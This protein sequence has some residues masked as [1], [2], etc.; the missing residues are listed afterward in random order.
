M[1]LNVYYSLI[2]P[3]MPDQELWRYLSQL[4]AR[5]QQDVRR[6]RQKADQVRTLTGKLLL[7]EAITRAGLPQT[8]ESIAYTDFKRP[9]IAENIDFNITH[10]GGCVACAIGYGMKLGIDVEELKHITTE[11][12]IAVLREEE[13]EEMRRIQADPETILRFWTRKEAIVKASGE[14][15]Y[16]QPQDIYFIDEL[17]AKTPDMYWYLHE[18][19]FGGGYIAYCATNVPGVQVLVQHMTY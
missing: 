16:K 15:L 4:P 11:D 17:S 1:D 9:F 7:K 10:S 5:L 12:I 8:L 13:L 14:G 2:D 18:L 3:A 19:D 6:Y